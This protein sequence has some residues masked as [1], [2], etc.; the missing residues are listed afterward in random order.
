MNIEKIKKRFFEE[1][2]KGVE[3]IDIDYHDYL[4]SEQLEE[5]TKTGLVDSLYENDWML[6][7][8]FDNID[9]IFKELFTK[10]EQD[11][12]N[13]NDELWDFFRDLCF[14]NNTSNPLKDL[15]EH[16]S[17]S[18][19][20]YDLDYYVDSLFGED[21]E[22]IGKDIA[23]FL[24]ISYK[25]YQKELNSMIENA[26]YGGI[27]VVLFTASP[28]DLFAKNGKYIQFIDDYELCIMDRFNGS[29]WTTEKDVGKLTFDFVRENLHNDEGCG[30]YS[31]SGDVCGMT[32]GAE[33]DFCIKHKI[34]KKDKLIKISENESTKEFL[35]QEKKY[36]E[37]FAKGGCSFGDM[38][39]KR[40]RKKE[41]INSFPCGTRCKACGTFW[42]D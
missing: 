6:E 37:V 28:A 10:K 32:I 30:G 41:Y 2:P 3:L 17:S 11:K 15:L 13:E 33:A 36:K 27:L 42:V 22:K 29:G 18:Y 14:E 1:Y 23:K 8:E 24:R 12:I 21:V 35:E 7:A 20:Y 40:H 26:H 19:F 5:L 31:F 9:Y 38:N 39:I 25:K 16:T 4:T 34:L